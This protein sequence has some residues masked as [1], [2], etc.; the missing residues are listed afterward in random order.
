MLYK[1]QNNHGVCMS[2]VSPVFY[3][4]AKVKIN[5]LTLSSDFYLGCQGK[6]NVE[7]QNKVKN[8]IHIIMENKIR[9]ASG[10]VHT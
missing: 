3:T 5:C 6:V 7:F 10:R 2:P 1:I 4:E 9:H 8:L